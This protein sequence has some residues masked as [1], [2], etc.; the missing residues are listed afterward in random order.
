VNTIA[1][2]LD[3]LREARHRRWVLALAAA[4]TLGLLA[5]SL[6]LRMDVVDGTL[7][8]TRLFGNIFGFGRQPADVALR[9]LFRAAVYLIFYGGLLFGIAGC[10]EFAPS[11]LS[12]GR[13][14]LLLALP[15]RRSE[16]LAG[17]FLGVIVLSIAGALY[18]AGGLTLVLGVKTGVWTLCA[19]AAAML[20]TIAFAPIYGAMLVAS[21][22][23]R[24][25]AI[26]AAVGGSLFIGGI[27]SSNR[28]TIARLF[29]PGISRSVF[30]ATTFFLPRISTLA[31]AS[32]NFASS[33]PAGMSE[34][35]SLVSGF[36]VFTL[37]VL[38][39]GAWKFERRDF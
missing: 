37:G 21:T 15:V 2:A 30:E 20:T 35:S 22:F 31:E 25:A 32:A 18:G 39:I 23:V 29:E 11:L 1:I 27:V 34:L 6:S 38:A 24:S 33:S 19:M 14:E 9:P 10:S 26:S 4:I 16:L 36:L 28:A 12:P 13:I 17:T 5:M 7:A 3:V 8:S